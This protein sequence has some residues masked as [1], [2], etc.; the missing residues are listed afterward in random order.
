MFVVDRVNQCNREAQR[1][2]LPF[3]PRR[4][5]AVRGWYLE[6][7]SKEVACQVVKYRRCQPR[8]ELIREHRMRWAPSWYGRCPPAYQGRWGDSGSGGHTVN[9]CLYVQHA[10]NPQD[11]QT[12]P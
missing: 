5:N 2:N 6:R 4:G 12:V 1:S 11:R 9:P 8:A 7:E 3:T 10:A